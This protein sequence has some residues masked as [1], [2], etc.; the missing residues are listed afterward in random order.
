LNWEG[1]IAPVTAEQTT[2]AQTGEV[3]PPIEHVE[4]WLAAC[5]AMPDVGDTERLAKLDAIAKGRFGASS[6][7][8]VLPAGLDTLAK[9]L[10]TKPAELFA[11]AGITAG[12]GVA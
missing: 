4:L 6:L 7:A 2:N 3:T 10:R 9:E 1:G 5:D 12:Q 8:G 11:K